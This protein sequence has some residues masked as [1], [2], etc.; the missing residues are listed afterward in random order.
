M[1]QKTARL[2]AEFEGEEGT[3]ARTTV[4]A[5]LEAYAA[6]WCSKNNRH[7]A[8]TYAHEPPF[9]QRPAHTSSIHRSRPPLSALART[10][11]WPT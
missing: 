9:A 2:S 5:F 8:P 1:E 7:G 11:S 3:I 6:S 10:D 4:Y